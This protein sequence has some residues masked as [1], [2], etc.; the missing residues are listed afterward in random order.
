MAHDVVGGP[1][2]KGAFAMQDVVHVWLGHPNH[3]S[4]SAFGQFTV[5]NAVPEQDDKSLLQVADGHGGLAG[6]F[7]PEIGGW[8][9]RTWGFRKSIINQ[10]E[11]AEPKFAPN[12]LRLI[13][14]LVLKN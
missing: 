4:Q 9:I 8:P 10:N 7:L 11:F 1:D 12:D 3:P 2:R 6:I 5:A 13:D 14:L